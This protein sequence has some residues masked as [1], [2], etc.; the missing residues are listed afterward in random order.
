MTKFLATI[1]W[2]RIWMP[3]TV[4]AAVVIW[5]LPAATVLAQQYEA[6]VLLAQ[7]LVLLMCFAITA[8]GAFEPENPSEL[9]N[10]TKGDVFWVVVIVALLAWLHGDN[11]WTMYWLPLAMLG[12]S[13]AVATLDLWISLRGG[14]AKLQEL[15]KGRVSI[16]R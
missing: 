6:W 14:T 4:I 13:A 15:D 12:V 16:G 9:L 2:I 3:I 11:G 5:Q 1:F 7:V 10:D 8:S